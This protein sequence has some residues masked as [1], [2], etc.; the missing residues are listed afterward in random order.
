MS[1][2]RRISRVLL[3]VSVMLLLSAFMF[4]SATNAQLIKAEPTTPTVNI[5]STNY[6][7]V[8]LSYLSSHP[9]GFRGF[10]VATRGIVKFYASI[11]MYEDFWLQA[12]SNGKIPVV[13][14]H[15]ISLDYL[16]CFR[17]FGLGIFRIVV[18]ITF[19]V[20]QWCLYLQHFYP[21]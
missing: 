1:S 12:Q 9:E 7:D 5:A 10:P 13:V 21:F 16:I 3:P 6:E 2:F 8:D 17:L 15:A 18:H 11:Y 19:L 20:S 4:W 14:S